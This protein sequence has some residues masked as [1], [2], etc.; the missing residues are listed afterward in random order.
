M[1][2]L[3]LSPSQGLALLLLLLAVWQLS[4]CAVSPRLKPSD[5][6]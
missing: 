3:Q 2:V 1:K 4:G 5:Q 6:P